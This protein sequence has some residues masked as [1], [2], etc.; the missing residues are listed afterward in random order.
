MLSK[1]NE[2]FNDD[3]STPEDVKGQMLST[4]MMLRDE[5]C[6]MKR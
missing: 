2:P 5:G 3:V 1:L 4:G 6:G